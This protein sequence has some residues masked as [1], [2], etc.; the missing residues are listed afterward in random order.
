M[1]LNLGCGG[2]LRR[3]WLNVDCRQL[4]PA[5]DEFLCCDLQLIDGHIPDE[6]VSRIVAR[7]VLECLPWR[8][9]DAVLA[10]L[11][12][13][14]RP[15]GTLAIRVPD[16]KE[17]VRDFL[18]H[19]LNHHQAQ[20]LLYGDQGIAEATYRNLWTRSELRRRLRMIGLK[21]VRLDTRGR[22]ILARAR[23]PVRKA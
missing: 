10:M 11:G 9:V 20:M 6:G 17:I 3:G 5:G 23:R 13:K 8:E 21:L 2:D 12:R 7:N 16:G 15:G 1:K 4:Y 14:L 22:Q 19:S 18:K